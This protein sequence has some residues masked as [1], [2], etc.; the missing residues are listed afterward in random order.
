[1]S[2]LTLSHTAR[3]S[4]NFAGRLP[5]PALNCAAWNQSWEQRE[6]GDVCVN[7]AASMHNDI[8]LEIENV[9][10]RVSESP[11]SVSVVVCFL[12]SE[13]EEARWPAG[14]T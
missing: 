14:C 13:D 5:L 2:A 1:M 6:D 10:I 7:T 8:V 4:T 3:L 12:F 9:L 11:A